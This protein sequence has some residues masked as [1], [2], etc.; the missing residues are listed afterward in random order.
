MYS[1]VTMF[2]LVR[3]LCLSLSFEFGLVLSAA[4][5]YQGGC[6]GVNT[7]DNGTI[8]SPRWPRTYPNRRRCVYEIR[9]PPESTI[10]LQFPTFHLQPRQRNRCL[11]WLKLYDGDNL[12]GG[13]FCGKEISPDRILTSETNKIT[14]VFKSNRRRVFPG[15]RGTYSTD[16]P[17][18]GS[19]CG[20]PVIPRT[21]WTRASTGSKIVGGNVAAPG[22]YP[23]QVALKHKVNYAHFCGG[24]L[25]NENWV[26][27]AAQCVDGDSPA[28]QFVVTVGEHDLNNSPDWNYVGSIFINPIYSPDTVENNI[29]LLKLWPP[30]SQNDHVQPICLPKQGFE[31]PPGTIVTV[32]G[33]G[34]T[35][36]DGPSSPVLLQ[37]DMPV[38]SAEK[39]KKV[40]RHLA[41][42]TS[43]MM[44]TGYDAGGVD[45]C[46][47]D[48]GGPVVVFPSEGP[49]YLAGLVSFGYKCGEVG[50]PSVNTRVSSYVDWIQETMD[51]YKLFNIRTFWTFSCNSSVF[52]TYFSA[53]M[54]LLVRVLC[55]SLSCGLVLSAAPTFNCGGVYTGDNGTIESPSWP[56]TYPN[57]RRCVYEIRAP[58]ESTI[59][60]QFP[61]FHLEPRWRNWRTRPGRCMDWMRLYDGDNL[62]G[63]PF[64]GKEISPGLVFTSETH[65]ITVVF[66]S[67]F[68]RV[69][70]GFRGTYS[71]NLQSTTL[72]PTDDDVDSIT[73]A[74]T[75]NKCGRP[76]VPRTPWTRPSTGNKIVGGNIAAPGSYPWQVALKLSFRGNIFC[77]G[78]LLNENWVVTTAQPCA[79]DYSTTRI[80][81]VV[82]EHDVNNSPEWKE[83][84]KVQ[85]I[86]THP[87]FS[88]GRMGDNIALLKLVSPVSLND[89]V[90][91]ICLPKQGFET[92][93]G[94]IV[95][96]TGWGRT[97]HGPGSPVLLQAD[98]PV[99]S[100]DKCWTSVYGTSSMIC[101]GYDAGGVDSCQGDSGGPVVVFPS[102]G[103]AYLIGLVGRG[104]SCG[105]PGYP[106]VNTR[107]SQFVDW[108]KETM[109]KNS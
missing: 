33:W 85:K 24:A 14:V 58:P 84:V 55:L 87:T 90:M 61:T 25:L 91:P 11:D 64:C 29:A 16:V 28:E 51:K 76:V 43:S 92:P 44:C 108:I 42:I 6:G 78:A 98:M 34:R 99:L 26:V 2:L 35:Y 66:K 22:S 30:V 27:T 94:T 74:Y 38:V 71:T 62:I 31:T 89:H 1:S 70:P 8:E 23:W 54:F 50:I 60:L 5:T 88:S 9:A 7:G 18:P 75:V 103:P 3:A 100:A 106:G 53:T 32:T 49:A 48:G 63:G 17:S 96:V 39:C 73:P 93:P 13:P 86:I 101:T 10:A 82:G 105:H 21:P 67:N 59:V 77:G 104:Y 109:D 69:F 56:H 107:V 83:S 80:V 4:P 65:K 95:T 72:Q 20:R 79:L 45:S 41:L 36:F 15:F 102:E 97:Y 46:Q 47:G 81:A 52:L 40:Y 37:A 68:R 19:K 57:R 12:I